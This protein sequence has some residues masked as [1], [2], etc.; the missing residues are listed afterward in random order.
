MTDQPA[1]GTVAGAVAKRA[2]ERTV[3]E[4]TKGAQGWYGTIAPAH[5][6]PAALVQLSLAQFGKVRD[7]KT[8]ATANPNAWLSVVAEAARLGLMPGDT[9]FYLPFKDKHEPSGWTITAV[10]HWTGEVDLMYRTGIV[11]TV[12]CEVVREKDDFAWD[13]STMLIPEHH[14]AANDSG[15]QGLAD[16]EDRGKLTGVYC[17]VRFKGGGTSYPTVMTAREVLRHRA[18]SRAGDAFWGP[19][20]PAEGPWTVDMWKK[21]GIHKHAGNVPVSAEY[22]QTVAAATARA[23]ETAPPGIEVGVS[24][25]PLPVAEPEDPPMIEGNGAPASGTIGAKVEASRAD[26]PLGKGEALNEIGVTWRTLG[27]SAPDGWGRVTTGLLGMLAVDEGADPIEVAR[28]SDL[29]VAQ[30]R[31]A[32]HQLG[33][34]L[35]ACSGDT[36]A[37]RTLL[38]RAAIEHG[39]W[40]GADPPAPAG[41]TTEDPQ[42]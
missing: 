16:Q 7:L 20:Y 24:D 31:Q 2:D 11:E 14:V 27:L 37:A 42:S 34:I 40:D 12:V 15:Q 29:S 1:A 36:G 22:R 13:P 33:Q 23:L 25:V 26:K 41:F 10:V 32:L 38:L 28:P 35:A 18:I 17:Y 19:A 6:N 4:R 5:A 30:A 39:Y 3:T 21:T 9:I 8:A